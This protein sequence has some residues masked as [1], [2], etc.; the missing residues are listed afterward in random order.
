MT[1]TF[2][3]NLVQV[4]DLAFNALTGPIPAELEYLP[5]VMAIS[6]EG[7]QL[8]GPVPVQRLRDFCNCKNLVKWVF[9]SHDGLSTQC[10]EHMIL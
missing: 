7:N 4:I 10:S 9:P 3:V 5:N 8:S 2:C 6:L 1:L